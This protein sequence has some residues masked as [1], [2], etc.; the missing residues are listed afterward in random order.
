MTFSNLLERI[1]DTETKIKESTGD[2][3]EKYYKE[4][5]KLENILEE[6]TR[7]QKY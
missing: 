5:E 4:L 2:S 6:R 3:R 7:R 1:E